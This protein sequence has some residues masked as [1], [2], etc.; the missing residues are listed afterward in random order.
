[1][2]IIASVLEVSVEDPLVQRAAAFV[3]LPCIML[4][5]APREILRKGLPAIDAH[6]DLLLDDMV[7]YAVAGLAALAQRI[8]V[9]RR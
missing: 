7:G 5:L 4:V 9:A 1:M 2:S 3:I 8:R 6:P